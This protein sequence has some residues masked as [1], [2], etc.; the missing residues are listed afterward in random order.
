[1]NTTI[2]NSQKVTDHHAIV[3]TVSVLGADISVLPT[4]EREI[5]RLVS[6]QLLCAVSEPFRYAE[7]VAVL[8]CAGY[9]FTVKGRETLADGWKAYTESEPNDRILPELKVNGE[10]PVKSVSLKEGTTTPPAHFTEDSLLHAMETAGKEEMPEDA[11]RKG[12]GTPATRAAILEKL[13]RN[14]FVERKK[15]GKCQPIRQFL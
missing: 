2:C 9:I 15:S 11:E 14:G 6:R 8:D 3:P 4:G 10:Y 1:M 5:L 13:I 12:L 7:T